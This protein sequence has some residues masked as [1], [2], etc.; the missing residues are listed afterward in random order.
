MFK[1]QIT[2]LTKGG[3]VQVHKGKGS[4]QGALRPHRNN[5]APAGSVGQPPPSPGA[6]INDYAKAT[7]AANPAPP[8]P[9]GLGTGDW[10]G[11]G[12]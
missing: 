2:P 11:I 12:Q 1:H 3:Q 6:S 5:P 7:P 4:R 9:D 10:P 8:A